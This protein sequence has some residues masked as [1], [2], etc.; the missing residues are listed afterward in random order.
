MWSQET[1][2]SGLP[3]WMQPVSP[4]CCPVEW[5][6]IHLYQP[7]LFGVCPIITALP[8]DLPDPSNMSS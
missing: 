8:G 1:L 2:G 4:W 5:L 7:G 3:L 6:L